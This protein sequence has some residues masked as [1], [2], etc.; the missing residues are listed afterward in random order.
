MNP[1]A[2]SRRAREVDGAMDGRTVTLDVREDLRRGEDPFDKITRAV[3]GLRAGDQLVVLNIFEPVPLYDV[4][5][6]QGFT[7]RTE[8]TPEGDWQVTFHREAAGDGDA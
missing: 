4:L 1:Q 7:H 8:R 2:A 5:G 6:A 3:K